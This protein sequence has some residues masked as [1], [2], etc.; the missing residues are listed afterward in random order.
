[1]GKWKTRY[2]YCD[3]FKRFNIH[4]P[5]DTIM[6]SRRGLATVV[7]MVFSIIALT[8]TVA[9]VSYSMN[10]LN[11][12]NNAVLVKNQGLTSTSNE[13]FEIGSVTIKNSKL[14]ITLA[15]TGAVPINFTKI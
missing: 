4:K 6:K 5:R 2:Y 9:Y 13:K 1:M 12:Y 10:I 15:N 8:T 14:N 7:G 11:Q 3:H